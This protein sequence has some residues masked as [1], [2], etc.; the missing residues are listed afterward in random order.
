MREKPKRYAVILHGI[1]AV[2]GLTA[3]VLGIRNGDFSKWSAKSVLQI[4]IFGA[5]PVIFAADLKEY[6]A[7]KRKQ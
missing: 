5:W 7:G 2:L 6:L 4:F 3:L 1:M